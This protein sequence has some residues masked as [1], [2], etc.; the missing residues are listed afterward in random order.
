MAERCVALLR[1]VNLGR[2]KRIA[3]AD[4][5]ALVEEL[6]FGD[7]RT[8][9]NSG[10]VVFTAPARSA[11]TAAGRIEEAIAARLGVQTR[12]TVLTGRELGGVLDDNPF[13]EAVAQPSRY[14]IAVFAEPSARGRAEP[15]LA[16]RWEP[17]RL[18][19]GRRAAYLWCPDGIA[20]G[21]L[22]EAVDRALRDGV[23]ARNW[24]TMTKLHDLT[25]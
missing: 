16:E 10:N 6:G 14:L 17:E 11:R 12:V 9:L 20:A 18:A 21:R 7:V 8:L 4:L 24:G 3:M 15:L 2:A 19:L 1:G 23:T 5:R 25:R 22:A 13:P